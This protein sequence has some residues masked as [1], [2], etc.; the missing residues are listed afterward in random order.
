MNEPRLSVIVIEFNMAREIARTILSLSPKVQ[1]GIDRDEYEI[2]LVDNGS[3]RPSDHTALLDCGANLTFHRM[4]EALPSPVRAVNAGLRLARGNLVGVMIDGARMVSPRLLSHAVQASRLYE[5]GVISPLGFHLG[6]EPQNDAV[7]KGYDQ[8]H[9][10]A[11]LASVDWVDDGYRLFDVAVIAPGQA[12]GWF[13]PL[14]ESTALFMTKS[15]WDELD[16]FD[17]RF[18]TPGGGLSNL[19]TYIRACRLPGAQPVMLLGEATFH[20]VHG[21]V[22][23]NAPPGKHP[24]DEFH[25]EYVAIRGGPIE[26]PCYEPV[27]FGR[28]RQNVLKFIEHPV[29]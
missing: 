5:R 20:Q 6:R 9:E 28:I 16:G 22:A 12:S 24:W 26:A 17:E 10:D 15:M 13:R 25:R 11:L 8:A 27:C 23:S 1:R 4:D 21:G 19:D 18:S 7:K 29:R 14:M 3:S 2:I